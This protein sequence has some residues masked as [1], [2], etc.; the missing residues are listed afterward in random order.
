MKLSENNE[1]EKLV[2]QLKGVGIGLS[3]SKF[4][5]L[6]FLILTEIRN[7]YV[8]LKRQAEIVEQSIDKPVSMASL[9]VAMSRLKPHKN[10]SEI[11]KDNVIVMKTSLKTRFVDK[12]AILTLG[13]QK[14][15][16]RT[17]KNGVIDKENEV[18][19]DWR[20]LAPK[21]TVSNWILDYKDSLTAL[22]LTG[23]RWS[24][25]A[26]AINKHLELNK[27]ISTNTLTSIISLSNK[28]IKKSN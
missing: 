3:L 11:K 9:S 26:E 21:E 25:I 18:L 6:N 2:S 27:T 15:T 7:L 16:I 10:N 22:N 1:L 14:E 5:E 19:I 8:P 13:T 23:W 12:N 24:Q 4:V 20:G 28:K 17:L